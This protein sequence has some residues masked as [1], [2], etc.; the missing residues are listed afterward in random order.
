MDAR[1]PAQ[2]TAA[3]DPSMVEIDI[4]LFVERAKN[5]RFPHDVFTL[6]HP[7]TMSTEQIS[8]DLFAL[9]VSLVWVNQQSFSF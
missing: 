9:V 4:D 3:A 7:L 1:R 8:C 6:V 5:V 2:D